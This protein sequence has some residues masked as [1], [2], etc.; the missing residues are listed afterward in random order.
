M[1]TVVMVAVVGLLGGCAAKQQRSEAELARVLR[2]GDRQVPVDGYCRGVAADENGV[3]VARC[4]APD[5]VR[6]AGSCITMSPGNVEQHL[7]WGGAE[8]GD[9]TSWTC[10]WDPA[11]GLRSAMAEVCCVQARPVVAGGASSS[12]EN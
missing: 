6:V 12:A 5:E 2:A 11:S 10:A 3:S 7:L 8:K 1:R 4:M 9:R